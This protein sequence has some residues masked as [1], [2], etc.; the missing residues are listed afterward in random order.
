MWRWR[1]RLSTQER[2]RAE[3]LIESVGRW[4]REGEPARSVAEDLLGHEI[5]SR[6]VRLQHAVDG[7]DLRLVERL[8]LSIETC[9]AELYRQ[10]STRKG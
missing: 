4:L 7:G 8:T 6:L 5:R 10:R 2:E 3:R 1:R 9:V